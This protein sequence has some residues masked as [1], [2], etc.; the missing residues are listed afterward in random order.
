[1]K[2]ENG[3]WIDL[4]NDFKTHAF[5]YFFDKRQNGFLV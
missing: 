5:Y 4:W 3:F 1:M 2:R